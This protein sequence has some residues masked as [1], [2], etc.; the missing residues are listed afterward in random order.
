[1]ENQQLI[2]FIKHS[3]LAGKPDSQIR[4][5]L[6]NTGWNNADIDSILNSDGNSQPTPRTGKGKRL[7]IT[8]IGLVVIIAVV[9]LLFNSH[10]I[11]KTTPANNTEK[12]NQ[13]QPSESSQI[14][15]TPQASIT[16]T[17][18]NNFLTY[19]DSV[20]EFLYPTTLSLEKKVPDSRQ[21]TLNL[22]NKSTNK[23]FCTVQVWIKASALS[24]DFNTMEND[25]E[26]LV[27]GAQGTVSNKQSIQ[28]GGHQGFIFDSYNPVL[29]D[30]P[31]YGSHL[32]IDDSDHYILSACASLVQ[33]DIQMFHD[34][35]LTIKPL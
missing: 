24:P 22:T 34:F 6:L 9:I 31:S 12:T 33:K 4:Q 15:I 2:D 32:L 29:S 26:S 16:S 13:P 1:M 11:F 5:E 8:I 10:I 25:L 14:T 7:I 20:V 23:L 35:F 18:T 21:Y 28:V 19:S 30:Q 17:S 3:R 27:T